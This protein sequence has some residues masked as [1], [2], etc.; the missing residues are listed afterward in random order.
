[1]SD[2]EYLPTTTPE[3]YAD[4]PGTAVSMN[5]GG[6]NF[7]LD[8]E[9]HILTLLLIQDTCAHNFLEIIGTEK[10]F[11]TKPLLVYY[12]WGGGF[13][14]LWYIYAPDLVVEPPRYRRINCSSQKMRA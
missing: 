11:C 1:M 6:D 14:A 2:F 3:N 4:N 10:K 12:E 5:N 13:D 7:I 8:E 9:K